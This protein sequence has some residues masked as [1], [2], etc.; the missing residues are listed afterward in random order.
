MERPSLVATQHIAEHVEAIAALHAL[1]EEDVTHH[2]RAI[3]RM[4][5]AIGRPSALYAV[6]MGVVAWAGCNEL[7][8]RLGR[9]PIDPAPYFWLQGG[10]GVA[11]LLMTIMIVTTQ[12]RQARLAVRR[13]HLD[14]QVNLLAE[15]KIAKLVDL[16]E[17]LRRDLPNVRDRADPVAQAMTKSIDPHAVQTVLDEKLN[18]AARADE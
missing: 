14:L 10:V 11:A 17:E 3:E 16:V 18:E 15:R 8:V 2:Q 12:H 5:H 6:V 7:L 4:T 13:A 1:A 9:A